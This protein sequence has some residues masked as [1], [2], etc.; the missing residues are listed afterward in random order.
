MRLFLRGRALDAVAKIGGIVATAGWGAAL[1][2]IAFTGAAGAAM[3]TPSVIGAAIAVI[4][5]AVHGWAFFNQRWAML[6]LTSA[7]IVAASTS[8]ATQLFKRR[9]PSSSRRPFGTPTGKSYPAT[10]QDGAPLA[11]NDLDPGRDMT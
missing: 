3:S 6:A 4:L 10:G 7:A 2:G 11:Q 9:S 8:T 5:L 1:A